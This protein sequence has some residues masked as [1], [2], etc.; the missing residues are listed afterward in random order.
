MINPINPDEAL[1]LMNVIAAQSYTSTF[2][3]SAI[4]RLQWDILYSNGFGDV[5]R[6][7]AEISEITV[8]DERALEARRK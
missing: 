7:M 8:P 3:I 2:L 4:K 5:L 6:R 1:R